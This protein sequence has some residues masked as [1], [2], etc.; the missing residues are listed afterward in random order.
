M[1]T[2]SQPT[3]TVAARAGHPRPG[4]GA[5][6]VV[7]AL[8]CAW[9]AALPCLAKEELYRWVDDTGTTVYSQRPPPGTTP[10]TAIKVDPGPPPAQVEQAAER[11]R[12]QG[13]QD[14]DKGD[15]QKRAAEPADKKAA[16]QARRQANCAAARKNAETL[17][18]HGQ[19]RL[20]MADGKIGYLSKDELTSQKAEAQ[21]QIAE[22]CK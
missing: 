17:E 18:T 3:D 7:F 13:Q 22:Y 5:R 20:R 19:G 15:Q 8:A 21:K 12:S 4:T 10:A 16:E 6:P 14:A 11:L 9:L 1:M 2:R